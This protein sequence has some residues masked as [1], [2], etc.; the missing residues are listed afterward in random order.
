MFYYPHFSN[1]TKIQD[2][3]FFKF[4]NF[5]TP[6]LIYRGSIE[7]A[8]AVDGAAIAADSTT[9]TDKSATVDASVKLEVFR[10]TQVPGICLEDFETKQVCP[11]KWGQ[12]LPCRDWTT[13]MLLCAYFLST[14]LACGTVY[15]VC[16]LVF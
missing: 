5:V 6:G 11:W 2:H 16:T 4:T 10:N 8:T 7:K 13:S 9:V 14:F 12:R 15:A 3:I 1:D